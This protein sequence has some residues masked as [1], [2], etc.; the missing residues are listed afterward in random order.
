MCNSIPEPGIALITT[1]G[2][3]MQTPAETTPAG[4]GFTDTLQVQ[5][6]NVCFVV[7]VCK[8]SIHSDT[9]NINSGAVHNRC[10]GHSHWNIRS[11]APHCCD[12]G[13]LFSITYSKKTGIYKYSHSCSKSFSCK[14]NCVN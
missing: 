13:D 7:I 1:V 11:H 5:K 14:L 12:I 6:L 4:N 8:F 2:S 9:A 10:N 3:V